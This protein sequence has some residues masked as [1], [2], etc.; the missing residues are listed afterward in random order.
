M[1]SGQGYKG[2]AASCYNCHF[3]A[4]NLQQSCRLHLPHSSSLNLQRWQWEQ[5]HHGNSKQ[6]WEWCNITALWRQS[7]WTKTCEQRNLRLLSCANWQTR[8]CHRDDYRLR[9]PSACSSSIRLCWTWKRKKK[10]KTA[11]HR[12]SRRIIITNKCHS[13]VRT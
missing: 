11:Q 8:P 6:Q 1:G 10:V 7:S 4:Q 12:I 9:N 3:P 13:I 5:Q 2:N